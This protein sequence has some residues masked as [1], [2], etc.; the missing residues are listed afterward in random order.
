MQMSLLDLPNELIFYEVL[1]CL[2]EEEKQILAFTCVQFSEIIE[3]SYRCDICKYA[4]VNNNP[5]ILKWAITNGAH[6]TQFTCASAAR[7]GNIEVLAFLKP[8]GYIFDGRI[9]S[10]GAAEGGQLSCLK[11][12]VVNGYRIDSLATITAA[13]NGYLDTMVWL[14]GENEYSDFN[15]C[16]FV[17]K[18]GHIHILDWLL[19]NTNALHAVDINDNNMFI[20]YAIEGGSIVS[21]KW[22]KAHD[23]RFNDPNRITEFMCEYLEVVKWF[24]LGST[25]PGQSPSNRSQGY[26]WTANIAFH[27]VLKDRLEVLESAVANG[28]PWD[29]KECLRIASDTHPVTGELLLP[30]I[31]EWLLK[32][33]IF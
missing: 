14:R 23:F 18:R 1:S 33:E 17:L 12:L 26:R 32:Y 9:A 7:K 6:C 3:R 27:A 25:N 22:L 24:L 16:P 4:A 10:L 13:K 31:H 11:W 5:T 29:H 28:C 8:Y 2:L 20:H 15:L 30:R 19:E 21:L